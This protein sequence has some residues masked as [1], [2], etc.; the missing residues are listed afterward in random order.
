M[1]TEGAAALSLRAVAREVGMASR[2]ELLTLLIVRA[3]D[4]LGEFTER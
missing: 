3:H 2:D 4:S 1:A